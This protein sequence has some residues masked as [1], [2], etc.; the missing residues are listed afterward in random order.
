MNLTLRGI[1]V[2]LDSDIGR[3]FL[4]DAV[5]AAENLISDDELQEVY[6]VTT[7]YLQS[8]ATNKFFARALRAERDRRVRSG[9][10]AREAASKY[11]IKSPKILDEIQSDETANARHKIESIR[12]LRQIAA[13]ENASGPTQSDRF[14]ITINIGDGGLRYNKSIAIDPNDGEEP[15]LVERPKK[16]QP[17]LIVAN[18]E[19]DDE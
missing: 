10:A 9:T 6:E 18:D 16:R 17:K 15:K 12:E 2:T 13:P 7:E 11:F 4:V 8:L 5:R 3:S 19:I 1:E 14:A